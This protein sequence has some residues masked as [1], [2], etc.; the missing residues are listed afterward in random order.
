MKGKAPDGKV[1]DASDT[2]TVTFIPAPGISLAKTAAPATY[3][4]AGQTITYTY[5]V[6]NSGN[7]PLS[8]ITPTDSKLG[9]IT[10]PTTTLDA[11]AS[12]TCTATHVTTAADLQTGHI[13]NAATVKGT[14]PDGKGV[15][16]SDTATV[17]V[18]HAPAISVAKTAAPSTYVASGETIT[19]TY[20]V[21]NSGNVPLSRIALTD[22]KLGTIR[23]PA[24]LLA[25][26]ASMRCRA[27]HVTTTADVQ[28]GHITNAATATGH[29]P[30]GAR[31]SDSTA[32][33]AT[34]Q[35]FNGIPPFA[36]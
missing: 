14:A 4:V 31:V 24:T 34:T 10:C 12:M 22:S 27:T 17:T 9:T 8:R 36:G 28:A 30:T 29:P 15:D 7:V 33:S 13:T 11:G 26:G 18:V 1:V 21:T 6:T 3:G 5:L 20:V 16:A 35:P 25:A 2:A 23:C 32:A 19:Y